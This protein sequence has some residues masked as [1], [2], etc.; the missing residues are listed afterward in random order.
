MKPPALILVAALS[1]PC[2]PAPFQK[3]RGNPHADHSYELSDR[4]GNAHV[5]H[6]CGDGRYVSGGW[7]GRWSAPAHSPGK[8]AVRAEW[9]FEPLRG[10]GVEGWYSMRMDLNRGGAGT[11]EVWAG[12][13]AGERYKV[14]RRRGKAYSDQE[15]ER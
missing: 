8:I 2:A 5:I 15:L 13:F 10:E 1:L 9:P 4:R 11:A 6:L 3:G 12:S 7:K 14:Q